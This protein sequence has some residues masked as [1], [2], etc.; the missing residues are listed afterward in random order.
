[1]NDSLL[2]VNK[3]ILEDMDDGSDSPAVLLEETPLPRMF[4]P[5]NIVHIYTHRGGK[6]I[7][8]VTA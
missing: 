3:D 6:F 8:Y 2:N 4:I 5:G 1:M 7:C